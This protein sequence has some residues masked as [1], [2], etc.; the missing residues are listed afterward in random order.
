MG[1]AKR[2]IGRD[3]AKHVISIVRKLVSPGYSPPSS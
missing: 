3:W 2:I 1:K